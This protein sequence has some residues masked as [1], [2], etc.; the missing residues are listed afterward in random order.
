MKIQP[1]RICEMP[2]KQKLMIG[3]NVYGKFIPVSRK[4]MSHVSD[5]S[6]DL[7]QQEKVQM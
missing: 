1:S 3:T 6:F 5:L 4:E 2:L 7:K